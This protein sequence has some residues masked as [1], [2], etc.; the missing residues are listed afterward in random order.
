MGPN[1]TF[2]LTTPSEREIV[3]TRT[4]AAPAH[5]V[6]DVVRRW[7]LGPDGWSMPTCEIDLRPGGALVYVWR[8]DAS[9]AEFGLTGTYRQIVRPERIVHVERFDDPTMADDATVTTTFEEHA[10]ATTVTL[11]VA[12]A[13]RAIRDAALKSGMGGG[14]AT[15][16][17]RL[18]EQLTSS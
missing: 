18:E 5:A 9:G 13:S 4:F 16:Y 10:G 2:R 12:Y 3:M 8:N 7:L 17:D 6:F 14:V 1:Q 15:S 11:T